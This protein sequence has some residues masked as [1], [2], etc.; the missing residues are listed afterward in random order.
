MGGWDIGTRQLAGHLGSRKDRRQGVLLFH[1]TRGSPRQ[2]KPSHHNVEWTKL[3]SKS[4]HDDEGLL[5]KA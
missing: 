1:L 4:Q 3:L 5:P 2:V